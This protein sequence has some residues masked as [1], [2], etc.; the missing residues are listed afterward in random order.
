MV[1]GTAAA[2]NISLFVAG[3]FHGTFYVSAGDKFCQE[4][5]AGFRF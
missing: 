5:G 1:G 2:A 4:Y 3:T